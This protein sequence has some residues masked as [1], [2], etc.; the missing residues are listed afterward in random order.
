M[1]TALI[2]LSFL[3]VSLSFAYAKSLY[4]LYIIG[5]AIQNFMNAK[6][7][8][9]ASKSFNSK[10]DYDQSRESF[11]KFLSDSREWAYDYIETV[12]SGLKNFIKEV[13][14]HI[15]YYDNY[16]RAVEGMIAPHD[17][18]LKT[19]SKELKELKK[20]LPEQVND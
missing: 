2:I 20:L 5:N 7:E 1:K 14:P 9:E 10:E 8:F 16:G 3:T 19:V 18:A 17:S 4:R 13:E 11:I 6:E 12:Q 15:D